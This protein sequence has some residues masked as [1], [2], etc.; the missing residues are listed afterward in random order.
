MPSPPSPDPRRSLPSV[1]D[2]IMAAPVRL[3]AAGLQH[4]V[5]VHL[6]RGILA[7]AR[8]GTLAPGGVETALVQQIRALVQPAFPAVINATGVVLHTNLG[9]A[10]LAAEAARAMAEAATTYTALDFDLATGTR[11]SRQEAVSPLWQA[12]LGAERAVVV[13][14][15]AAGT[16]L[17]LAAL[18]GGG[19]VLVSRGQ[20]VEI[21]GGFRIPDILRLAGARLVEVGTTNRTYT[22]DYEAA[23]SPRTRAILAVHPSNFRIVGFTHAP[24]REELASLA[25]D[26]GI[27]YIEDAGSGAIPD[28]SAFGLSPE[29][30]PQQALAQGADIV[31]FPTDKLFGGP[32]GGVIAGREALIRRIMAHPFMRAMRTDKA[33]LAGIEATARIYLRGTHLLDIPVWQMI[34]ARPDHLHERALRWQRTLGAGIVIEGRSAI[35]GGSLPGETLPTWLLALRPR[36]RSARAEAARLRD[37]SPP[38]LVRVDDGQLLADPRTVLP[39]QDDALLAALAGRHAQG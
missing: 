29:P 2:L 15:N 16:L 1:N 37:A 35:G 5:V 39:G 9:R 33:H 10:P 26:R 27:L 31:T 19:D 32:Q 23:I 21:G 3:A 6:A 24:A 34:T 36:R 18:C 7:A 14:N 25:H 20:A 30:Q 13:N 38:V 12:L 4:Q 28:T 8:Q 11:A 22:R 17:A